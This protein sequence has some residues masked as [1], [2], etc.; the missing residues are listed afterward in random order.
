[1]EETE[2]SAIGNR[3]VNE[4]T[5][6]KSTTG[7]T[8]GGSGTDSFGLNA[9]PGGFRDSEGPFFR[10][11]P[12]AILRLLPTRTLGFGAGVWRLI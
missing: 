12:I 1:M 9:L 3:G 8:S 11:A 5:Q 4:G 2:V 7:W 6:L 10:Q